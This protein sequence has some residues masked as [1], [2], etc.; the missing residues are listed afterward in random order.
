LNVAQDTR[1]SQWLANSTNCPFTKTWVED[2]TD[3][4]FSYNVAG[5]FGSYL[6]RRYGIGFY[7]QLL[8]DTSS[9]DSEQIMDHAIRQ[10]GGAGLDA[11]IR[12]WGSSL[13]LLPA[14]TSPAGFGYPERDDSGFVLPAFDGA[15]FANVRKLPTSVP[16]SLQPYGHFPVQRALTGAQYA[17]TIAVPP[18]SSLSVIV[19]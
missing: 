12:D 10:A 5:S 6:L 13:A 1:F 15:A 19:K 4:C 3:P 11:A 18:G 9:L 2:T 8:R 14:A 17:E 7:Q 16:R